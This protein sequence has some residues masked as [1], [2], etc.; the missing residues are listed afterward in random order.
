[1]IITAC[2]GIG[3][4]ALNVPVQIPRWELMSATFTLDNSGSIAAAAVPI[5]EIVF[6]GATAIILF[7]SPG[8]SIPAGSEQLCTAG[9]NLPNAS[10]L[11]SQTIALPTDIIVEATAQVRIFWEGGE[12]LTTVTNVVLNV[13]E[14]P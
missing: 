5:V 6:A 2:D 7:R 13:R 14:H 11:I 9:Q 12:M 1:M 8:T 4:A 10:P 3:G